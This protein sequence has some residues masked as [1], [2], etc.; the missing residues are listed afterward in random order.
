V[1]LQAEFRGILLR[2]EREVLLKCGG[3][4]EGGPFCEGGAGDG[5]GRGVGFEEFGGE[6][7][8]FCDI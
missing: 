6:E 1:Q 5:W 2:V 7:V 8:G 3:E 4:E